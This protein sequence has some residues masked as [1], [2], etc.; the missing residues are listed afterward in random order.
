MNG[1]FIYA[2]VLAT[3]LFIAPDEIYDASSSYFIWSS[4]RSERG[5]TAG[6]RPSRAGVIYKSFVFPDGGAGPKRSATQGGPA[7]SSCSSPASASTSRRPRDRSMPVFAA[8]IALRRGATIVASIVEMADQWLIKHLLAAAG[9]RTARQAR[10]RAHR[11]HRQA[12]RAGPWLPRHCCATSPPAGH[13]RLRH[14]RRQHRQPDLLEGCAASSAVPEGHGA[15]HRR[16]LHRR[17]RRDLPQMV[18]DAL[19][20][21]ADPDV[22][23]R[24]VAQARADADRPHVDVPR[25]GSLRSR[26]HRPHRARRRR[27]LAASGRSRC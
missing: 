5:A 12:R 11:R 25:R 10:I 1:L 24:P 7:T 18:L 3:A 14:R 27:A 17:G 6:R 22:L 9:R 13:G 26:L 15:H 4:G 19:R 20:P 16:S 23:D 21:A 8:A 2:F